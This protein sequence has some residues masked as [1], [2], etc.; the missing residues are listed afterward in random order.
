LAL[1]VMER[2]NSRKRSPEPLSQ[3][4]KLVPVEGS[5]T[6]KHRRTKEEGL[7]TKNWQIKVVEGEKQ[8]KGQLTEQKR[9]E[10]VM[11][12]RNLANGQ[13]GEIRKDNQEERRE[14]RKGKNGKAPMKGGKKMKGGEAK[15]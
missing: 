4:K 7:T 15:A 2:W 1:K 11:R 8:K 9:P 13:R 3:D 10:I 14:V 12:R 6:E 5:G